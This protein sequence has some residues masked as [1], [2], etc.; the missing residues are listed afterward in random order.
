MSES[1]DYKR[2]VHLSDIKIPDTGWETEATDTHNVGD[3]VGKDMEWI[4]SGLWN[5]V[6]FEMKHGVDLPSPCMVAKYI[7]ACIE[8]KRL[9]VEGKAG[10]T[11]K[12]EENN[13]Q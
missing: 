1:N 3:W 2:R 9:A 6:H 4:L 5:Q 12:K 7:D 13:E 8:A 10:E 11:A